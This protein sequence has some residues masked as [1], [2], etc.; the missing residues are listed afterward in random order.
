MTA[1]FG[2]C[3]VFA[4]ASAFLL[5]MPARADSQDGVGIGSSDATYVVPG[6][7]VGGF[8]SDDGGYGEINAILPLSMP[9]SHQL[10]FIGADG[11]LFGG[12]LSNTGD[13]V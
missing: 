1:R 11:K 2:Y 12:G 6:I 8:V 13:S 3:T 5:S 7:E 9:T 10:F 4:C